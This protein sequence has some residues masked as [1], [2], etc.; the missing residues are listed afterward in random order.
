MMRANVFHYGGVKVRLMIPSLPSQFDHNVTCQ[1]SW[2][3][4]SRPRSRS[5]DCYNDAYL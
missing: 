5:F 2:L 4:I 1:T 3:C